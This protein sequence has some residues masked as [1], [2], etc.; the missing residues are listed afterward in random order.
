MVGLGVAVGGGVAVAVGLGLGVAVLLLVGVVAGTAV[1]PAS[2]YLLGWAMVR[3]A[4]V[5]QRV[6]LLLG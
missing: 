1:V 6:F 3:P 5:W 2:R 4:P